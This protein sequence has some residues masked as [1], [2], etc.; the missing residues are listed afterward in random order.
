MKTSTWA[1]A[2]GKRKVQ[3]AETLAILL[4]ASSGLDPE[5][6]AAGHGD[7]EWTVQYARLGKWEGDFTVRA[8]KKQQLWSGFSSP[9]QASYGILPSVVHVDG[10]QDLHLRHENAGA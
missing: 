7:E 3:A 5:R 10:V 1:T 4:A 6:L 2:S 9:L 8:F